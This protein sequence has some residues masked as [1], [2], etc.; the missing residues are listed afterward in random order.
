MAQQRIKPKD[1][2]AISLLN[3]VFS[4]TKNNKF[5]VD[6]A[7]N[8]HIVK[9]LAGSTSRNFNLSTETQLLNFEVSFADFSG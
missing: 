9:N 8:R 2:S 4:F 6:V 1:P 7:A 3:F 5:L